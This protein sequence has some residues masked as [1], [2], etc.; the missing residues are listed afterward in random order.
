MIK[1][2]ISFIYFRATAAESIGKY[3]LVR[4]YFSKLATGGHNLSEAEANFSL[5]E[6]YQLTAHRK[7]DLIVE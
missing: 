6:L 1:L 3:D 2:I 5:A 7:Q 4:H